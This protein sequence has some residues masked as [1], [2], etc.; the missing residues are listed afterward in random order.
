M[1]KKVDSNRGFRREGEAGE[2]GQ[3]EEGGAGAT[4]QQSV[5]LISSH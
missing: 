5:R 1:R 2:K 4:R 3:S